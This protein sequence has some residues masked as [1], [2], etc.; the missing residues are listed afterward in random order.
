MPHNAAQPVSGAATWPS[1]TST[2]L[3]RFQHPIDSAEAAAGYP[4]NFRTLNTG[5][6]QLS[7]SSVRGKSDERIAWTTTLLAFSTRQQESVTVLVPICPGCRGCANAE[8]SC[9]LC[10]CHALL[11][12]KPYDL[13]C[14]YDVLQ[15]GLFRTGRSPS[16]RRLALRPY[17]A[18]GESQSVASQFVRDSKGT[19]DLVDAGT[20]VGKLHHLR[21]PFLVH[22]NAIDHHFD[23]FCRCPDCVT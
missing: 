22:R 8:F 23:R 2:C 3:R 12:T 14:E 17:A 11:F 15:S 9:N 7:D 20:C 19:R 21:R 5:G 4:G 18:L 16:P 1:S 13:R 6:R 10:K